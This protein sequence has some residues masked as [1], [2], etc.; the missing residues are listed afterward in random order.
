MSVERI[1]SSLVNE[2]IISKDE[3]EIVRFGLESL[4]GNVL[5]IILI[6]SIGALF[7]QVIE[8]ILIW[9]FLFPL[10]KTVGGFHA[11]SKTKCLLLTIGVFLATFILF[12]I[13]IW[14]LSILIANCFVSG[15]IIWLFAPV[16]NP[17]KKLDLAARKVYKIS[18]KIILL[19]EG[20]LLF[21]SLC[22]RWTILIKCVSMALFI[23]SI[24][25]L[26]GIIA[27]RKKQFRKDEK[28]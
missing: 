6:V 8:S 16:D 10:R 19:L 24:S 21:L 7:E 22:L 28:V 27:Y 5:S 13:N 12:N 18:S 23:M 2:G 20:V 25:V 9:L 15:G 17:S 14:P 11:S 3:Q 26:M 4:K 1:V